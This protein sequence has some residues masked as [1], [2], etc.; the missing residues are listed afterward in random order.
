MTPCEFTVS[1]KPGGDD[2]IILDF[3]NNVKFNVA[4]QLKEEYE[5]KTND[6]KNC[7]VNRLFLYTDA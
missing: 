1:K 6:E 3:E 5:F 2:N 4:K 7:P